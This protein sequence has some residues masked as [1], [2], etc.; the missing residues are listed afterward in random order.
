MCRYRLH[1]PAANADV[2][3]FTSCNGLTIDAGVVR[4]RSLRSHTVTGDLSEA[5]ASGAAVENK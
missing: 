4:I 2:E 5:T 3:G 1:L